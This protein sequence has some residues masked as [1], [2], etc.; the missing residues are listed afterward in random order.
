MIRVVDLACFTL[1]VHAKVIAYLASAISEERLIR[2]F[3]AAQE[4]GFELPEFALQKHLST[5]EGYGDESE[6]YAEIQQT[7]LRTPLPEL[8]KFYL[9]SFPIYRSI[10]E[11][12]DSLQRRLMISTPEQANALFLELEELCKIWFEG[13]RIPEVLAPNLQQG[14]LKLWA[15]GYM[16]L[17]KQ[18]GFPTLSAV[19]S[20]SDDPASSSSHH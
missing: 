15:Q 5:E 17:R 12:P 3:D 14:I 7:V 6:C 19:Q 10:V 20:I 4:D 2:V 11:T 13:L 18:M 16:R 8:V 9:W 1:E